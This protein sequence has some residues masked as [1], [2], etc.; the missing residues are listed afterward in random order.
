M[1]QEPIEIQAAWIL[2][3]ALGLK[4]EGHTPPFLEGIAMALAGSGLQHPLGTAVKEGSNEI[5][6][7]IGDLAESNQAIADAINQVAIAISES[8]ALRSNK[9]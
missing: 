4:R 8:T 3:H 2:A 1:K 6:C 7:A 9:S 5:A